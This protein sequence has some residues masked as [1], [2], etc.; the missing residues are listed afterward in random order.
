M[1][2]KQW[3]GYML[4]PGQPYKKAF[5]LVGL[6][7]AGKTTFM[8]VLQTFVGKGHYSTLTLHQIGKDTFLLPN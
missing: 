5:I 1:L 6:K 4:I 8:K 7:H 3:L 2:L